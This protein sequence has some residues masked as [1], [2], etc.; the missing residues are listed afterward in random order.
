MTEGVRRIAAERTRQIEEE[1]MTPGHDDMH[2]D[3]SLVWAAVCYAAP[4]IVYVPDGGGHTITFN[5]PWPES[6]RNSYGKLD[7][8]SWDK[9]GPRPV[10]PNLIGM[11]LQGRLREL[12]KAGALIAA[13]IDRL[14]RWDSQPDQDPG[15]TND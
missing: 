1:G 3:D 11:K 12:E 8:A 2:H 15:E 14:L 13:E 10:D 5:D 9:R 7:S 6:W 4:S